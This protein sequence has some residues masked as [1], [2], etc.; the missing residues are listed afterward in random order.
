M[1]HAL[2]S[3]GPAVKKYSSCSAA[4]P[5]L[6]ILDKALQKENVLISY[7]QVRGRACI[8]AT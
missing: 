2:T 5:V 1:V 7:Q 8:I 3:S 4:Y 6:I